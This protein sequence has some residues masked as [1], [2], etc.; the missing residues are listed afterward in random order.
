M[1]EWHHRHEVVC[2]LP[3]CAKALAPRP[4]RVGNIE[5]RGDRRLGSAPVS[6]AS[7]G[8][9]PERA[10]RG[11]LPVGSA[12]PPP[13]GLPRSPF[14]AEATGIAVLR[15]DSRLPL[16]MAARIA[17][18]ASPMPP[19]PAC[20]SRSDGIDRHPPR[21]A[22][23]SLM[24]GTDRSGTSRPSLSADRQGGSPAATPPPVRWCGSTCS[25]RS[26]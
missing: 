24:R 14:V 6:Y 11:R 3:G 1:A 16:G 5:F 12:R 18:T 23:P 8:S 15:D 13:T 25:R 20:L 2:T 26:W 17:N 21:R 10:R 22:S 4:C 9:P 7:R 19:G